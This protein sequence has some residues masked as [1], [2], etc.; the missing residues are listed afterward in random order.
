MALDAAH[1]E[2]ADLGAIERLQHVVRLLRPDDPDHEFHLRSLLLRGR[3]SLT[4]GYGCAMEGALRDPDIPAGEVTAYRGL[5]DGREVGS[6]TCT[7]EHSD[8]P[9]PG[10]VQRLD[11]TVEGEARYLMDLRFDRARG[12]LLANHYRLAT[13]HHDTPVAVEEGWFREVRRALQFGGTLESYPR[14]TMPLLGCA[15]GLRGLEFKKGYRRTL[16]LWLANTVHWE[17]DLRVE[18]AERVTVPAG[19]LHAW[20]V[21]ARPSF[22]AVAKQ[23]DRVIGLFLPPFTLHFEHGDPHRLLRFEFPTG[24]F[25]WNPRAL[26]EATALE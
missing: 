12:N 22:E 17:I 1:R 4:A 6:G 7:V 3:G 11:F 21:R 20:R 16:P 24:P 19:T 26:I 18:R 25:P 8:D 5:I 15:V 13:H 23:L 14:A 9:K 2:P 10:Y